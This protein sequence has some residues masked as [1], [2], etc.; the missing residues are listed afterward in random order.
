MVEI[1]GVWLVE[2]VGPVVEDGR[3]FE[4]D[5]VAWTP[6]AMSRAEAVAWAARAYPD[7]V[8]VVGDMA[9]T[10]ADL[11]GRALADD[12]ADLYA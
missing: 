9:M 11:A 10:E 6:E 1:R 3:A 8:C 7:A 2:V 12:E 4:A 5:G